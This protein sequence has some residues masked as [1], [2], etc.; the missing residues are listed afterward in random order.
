ML[1]SERTGI[2]LRYGD[3]GPKTMKYLLTF[4]SLVESFMQMISVDGN[5][6]KAKI[7]SQTRSTHQTRTQRTLRCPISLAQ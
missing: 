2:A 7:A 6:P 4:T 1:K 3:S 5:F